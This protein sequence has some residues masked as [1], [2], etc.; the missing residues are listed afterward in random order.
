MGTSGLGAACIFCRIS[1]GSVSFTYTM[2]A[3]FRAAA[4]DLMMGML[5]PRVDAQ[6]SISLPRQGCVHALLDDI[7]TETSN[8]I[9]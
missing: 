8:N 3:D 7:T 5:W 6:S 1:S 4:E 2:Q 9:D